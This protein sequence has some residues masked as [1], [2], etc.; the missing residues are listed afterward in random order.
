MDYNLHSTKTQ[1]RSFS[2]EKKRVVFCILQ[3]SFREKSASFAIFNFVV[4]TLLS[5]KDSHLFAKAIEEICHFPIRKRVQ[6]VFTTFLFLSIV[7]FKKEFC[8]GIAHTI[9]GKGQGGLKTPSR[10]RAKF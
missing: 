2:F 5:T 7:I 8:R 6:C 10:S 9:R 1:L 3:Q 4:K